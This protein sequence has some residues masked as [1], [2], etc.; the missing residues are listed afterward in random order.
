MQDGDGA[1]M[2]EA[3]GD[4][5]GDHI[6]EGVPRLRDKDAGSEGVQVPREGPYKHG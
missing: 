1:E 3:S 2:T 4:R 5:V 6:G